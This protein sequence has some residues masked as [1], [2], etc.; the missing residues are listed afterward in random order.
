MLRVTRISATIAVVLAVALT[1]GGCPAP[2]Q[3]DNDQQT[4]MGLVSPFTAASTI[5]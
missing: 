5:D 1:A 2:R 4:G 3:R